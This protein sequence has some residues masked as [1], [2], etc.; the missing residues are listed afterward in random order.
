MSHAA[1]A[2]RAFE[3]TLEELERQDDAPDFGDPAALGRRAALLAAAEAVWGRH[4]GPLFD[5]DQTR[6]LLNVGSRQAVSDLARRGR[7]L[8]L[9]AS[10][11]RKLYPAFQFGPDGRPYA[12][13]ARVLETFAGAVES[14]YTIAS[15]F[16][17]PQDLLDG[18]TPAAW[19]RSRREPEPLLEAAS[20]VAARLA[21]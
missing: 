1:I 2:A 11:G 12:E 20:H 21:R 8:A 16:V 10:G 3:K 18:E 15:W 19:M 4:L 6:S 9:E 14:P 13:V 17:S 5:M 7:L